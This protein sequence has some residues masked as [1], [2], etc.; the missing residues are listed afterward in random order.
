MGYVSR[1]NAL[2]DLLLIFNDKAEIML[3]MWHY[4]QSLKNSINSVF[5]TVALKIQVQSL[6]YL[7]SH[8]DSGVTMVIHGSRLEGAPSY[9]KHLKDW[10]SK[11]I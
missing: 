2:L 6:C 10:R 4:R 9:C 8:L 5:L 1:S 3:A 7:S 11:K